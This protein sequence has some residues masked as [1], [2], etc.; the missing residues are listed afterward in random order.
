MTSLKTLT[1]QIH[2][3]GIIALLFIR[4]SHFCG[5]FQS[6]GLKSRYGFREVFLLPFYRW[7]KGGGKRQWASSSVGSFLMTRVGAGL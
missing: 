5:A 3:F 7:A 2:T 4:A 1:L 6:N